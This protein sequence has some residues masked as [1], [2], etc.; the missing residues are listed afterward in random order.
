VSSATWWCIPLPEFHLTEPSDSVANLYLD[1]T[2]GALG[3]QAFLTSR[4]AN[5][6]RNYTGPALTSLHSGIGPAYS[7]VPGATSNGRRPRGGGNPSPNR[8]YGCTAPPPRVPSHGV[9]GDSARTDAG[10]PPTPERQCVNWERPSLGKVSQLH[11]ATAPSTPLATSPR[12]ACRPQRRA[13][14]VPAR[15]DFGGTFTDSE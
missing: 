3:N 9:F 14:G 10:L 4:I 8:R 13:D 7:A 5:F 6:H 15:S 2:I 12:A 1:A 11:T